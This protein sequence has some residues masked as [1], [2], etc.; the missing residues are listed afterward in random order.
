MSGVKAVLHK[1][2]HVAL[3]SPLLYVFWMASALFVGMFFY[4]GLSV[5]AEPNLRVLTINLATANILLI[6][7]IA[8]GMLAEE[9]KQGTLEMLLTLPG[10]LWR[11]VLGKFIA[12]MI[13][14]AG[15][16]VCSLLCIGVLS[17]LGTPDWGA[18]AT[19]FVGQVLCTAFCLSVSMFASGLTKEPIASGL[20]AILCLLPFWM[21]SGLIQ[22]VDAGWIRELMSDLSLLNHLT[23]LSKG[24]LD[25]TDVVWFIGGT[26]YFLWL[27]VRLLEWKRC[28]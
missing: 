13:L 24:V 27:T 7:L 10:G 4:L 23:P 21:G 2:L 20:L 28:R 9:E 5:S 1:E 26:G 15:M 8:M 3:N 22:S 19:A 17:H 12:G 25:L 6:P 16:W 14:S 18:I 11:I